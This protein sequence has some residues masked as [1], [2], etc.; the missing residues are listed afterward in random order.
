MAI[1]YPVG[2]EMYEE[3]FTQ[4][5]DTAQGLPQEKMSRMVNNLAD[6]AEC[7]TSCTGCDS[8]RESFRQLS[9]FLQPYV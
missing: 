4:V 6:G 5:R 7:I 1:M 2:L 3:L 9:Y 8:P